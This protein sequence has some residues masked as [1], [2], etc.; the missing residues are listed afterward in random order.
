MWFCGLRAFTSVLSL[1]AK[2]LHT[3]FLSLRVVDS[4]SSPW[5]E[6]KNGGTSCDW[7]SQLLKA[8]EKCCSVSPLPLTRVTSK[9]ESE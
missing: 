2:N 1:Q 7:P 6:K 5:A 9:K 8:V 3:N 4:L